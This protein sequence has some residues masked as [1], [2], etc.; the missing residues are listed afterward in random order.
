VSNAEWL[1]AIR[2]SYPDITQAPEDIQKAV[3]KAEKASSKALSKDLNK[4]SYQVGKAARQ[5]T[6]IKEARASHRQNWLKHLRDSVA[7]WQKQLQVFKD[8]QKEYGEQM[9]KAQQELT[10]ARRHLQNLNKQAA[11]TGT[12]VP[13]EAGDSHQEPTDLE[14]SAAFE[15][16]AQALV[17]QVQESL[18]QSIAAASKENDAMEVPSDEETDRRSKRPRSMEPFGGP[19][20]G[21]GGAHT[22][23]PRS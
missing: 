7:S 4:A 14:A 18:Q 2:K 3:E 10:A 11:A 23:S 19:D 17:Q 6:N 15:V 9:S 21:L 22:S 13:T 5:L 20:D 16:E 12:P 1:A 8:Q